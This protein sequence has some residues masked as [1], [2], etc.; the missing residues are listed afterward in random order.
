MHDLGI[1]KSGKPTSLLGSSTAPKCGHHPTAAL[2]PVHLA[3]NHEVVIS[4]LH[5]VLQQAKQAQ[6]SLGHSAS[7]GESSC[8]SPPWT[9]RLEGRDQVPAAYQDHLDGRGRKGS[10]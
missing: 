9:R 3:Q 5:Q 4:T 7:E 6:R 2:L 8:G 10:G 1:N